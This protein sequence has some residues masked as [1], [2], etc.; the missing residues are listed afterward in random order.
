MLAPSAPRGN[1]MPEEMPDS[2]QAIDED[3][4]F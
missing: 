1:D 2:F 3:V 4:P